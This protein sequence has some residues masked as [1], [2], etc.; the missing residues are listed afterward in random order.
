MEINYVYLISAFLGLGLGGAL[1]R[2][3]SSAFFKCI[4]SNQILQGFLYGVA[5]GCIV[6]PVSFIIQLGINWVTGKPY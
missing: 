6:F 5:L 4:T 2:P 1:V 3:K